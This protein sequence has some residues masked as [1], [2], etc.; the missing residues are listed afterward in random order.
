MWLSC[1]S[2]VFRYLSAQLKFFHRAVS[3]LTFFWAREALPA[4]AVIE[5]PAIV[6]QADSTLVLDPGSRAT[7]DRVGNLVVELM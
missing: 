5:G 1:G 6:E 7:V 4:D 3:L 2:T